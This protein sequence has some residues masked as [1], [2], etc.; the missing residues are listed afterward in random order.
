MKPAES[1]KVQK[2]RKN[3]YIPRGLYRRAMAQARELDFDFTTAVVV[4]LND[5]VRPST[6]DVGPV[7]PSGPSQPMVKKV[8]TNRRA[9]DRGPFY[10]YGTVRVPWAQVRAAGAY[11]DRHTKSHPHDLALHVP[12]LR[13]LTADHLQALYDAWATEW[14]A[15]QLEKEQA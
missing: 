3:I 14:Y 7:K 1:A 4:A 2:I 9:E 11:L 15:D 6:A 13:G 10:M 8:K 12:E 5:W